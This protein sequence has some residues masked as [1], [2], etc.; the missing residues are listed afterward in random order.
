MPI[1]AEA[2]NDAK[3]EKADAIAAKADGFD[4]RL[5]PNQA[6]ILGWTNGDLTNEKNS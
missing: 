4:V 2:T 5:P 6:E 3:R 1:S